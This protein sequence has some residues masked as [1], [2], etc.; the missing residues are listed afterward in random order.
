ME[1][2]IASSNRNWTAPFY[3]GTTDDWID[4]GALTSDQLNGRVSGAS[5]GL[6]NTI[7]VKSIS[8]GESSSDSFGHGIIY[9]GRVNSTR[10]SVAFAQNRGVD[11][12]FR[13]TVRE[14]P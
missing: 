9:V 12:R 4:L 2:V 5:V 8:F 3:C 10:M 7:P 6:Q 1:L 11:E 14:I 13:M